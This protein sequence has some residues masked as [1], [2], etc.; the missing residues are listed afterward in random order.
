MKVYTVNLTEDTINHSSG[1]SLD[2]FVKVTEFLTKIIPDKDEQ[3]KIMS[4]DLFL[5]INYSSLNTTGKEKVFSTEGYSLVIHDF[6]DGNALI[7]LEPE[8]FINIHNL[9]SNSFLSCGLKANGSAIFLENKAIEFSDV[10][11]DLS[12]NNT[13]SD[14]DKKAILWLENGE[15]GMSS[16]AL[17]YHLGSDSL[18]SYMEKEYS[19]YSFKDHPH[20]NSDLNRC[21]KYLEA[22]PAGYEKLD[23][24]KDVSPEWNILIENFPVLKEQLV[25]ALSDLENE[26]LSNNLYQNMRSLLD[27]TK[28][29]MKP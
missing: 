12:K 28:K 7:I 3:N 1:M 18:K 20:D 6:K 4:N 21:Y 27:S 15:R 14:D 9:K 5:S 26:E 29:K 2:F 25:K 16:M 24:I 22:V 13:F 8:E 19:D 11:S 23:K 10:S 17:C